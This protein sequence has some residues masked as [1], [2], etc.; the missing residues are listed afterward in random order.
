MKILI[1]IVKNNFEL[2]FW[3]GGLIFLFLISPSMLH[4]SFCPLSN[5]G[6][7]FCP[8]CGLGESI[9]HALYFNLKSSFSA[10]PLGLLAALIIFYRIIILLNQSYKQLKGRVQNV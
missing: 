4:F 8:G 6:F 1:T 5:L 10:H 7:S 2:F 9:H 3:G